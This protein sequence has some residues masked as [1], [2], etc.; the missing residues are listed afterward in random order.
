MEDFLILQRDPHGF[1]EIAFQESL[2]E[3]QIEVLQ[4]LRDNKYTTVRSCHDVGKTFL[5][6][7]AV[8]WFLCS[9]FNSKIITSAPTFRQVKDILWRE[10]HVAYEKSQIQLPG[11]VLD[12]EWSIAPDWFALGLSTNEPTRLQGFHADY[13][14][15]L[16]D[17]AAGI[18]QDIFDASE[19]IVTSEHAKILYL[20]NP[21]GL[22]GMFYKSF[23]LANFSKIHISAFDSPNFTTFG[24]TLDDIRNGKWQEKI[25]GPLPRPYLITP[26]WVADKLTRWG[27]QSPMW[28]ARVL[29]EF[30]D[31]GED[32]LIPLIRIEQSVEKPLSPLPDDPEQIGIDVARFGED[33]S[34]FI[35]RKGP[36][37]LE[38]KEFTEM[39][40]NALADLAKDFMG[41]HPYARVMIDEIGVGAGVVD[42]LRAK[43]ADTGNTR[44]I[45][46]INVATASSKP[47]LFANKRA[48]IFWNLR[49]RF[50]E[51]NISIPRD[52]DLMS[53][54]S[55]LKFEYT[56]KG[57]IRIESK[58]DMKKR[59]LPSPDKAD[60]LAL[61]FGFFDEKP[62]VT[63]FL[64][65]ITSLMQK[66]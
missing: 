12:T 55:N 45:E 51:G 64:K 42:A 32:T 52:E 48:E 15:F 17:E 36:V 20:G 18:P 13:L 34:V 60:A 2:W 24:I 8:I 14:L 53:Q 47:E 63:Q 61:A 58:E 9:F 7:R 39:D 43:L 37:L 23:K 56:I 11:Q 25:T 66:K 38:T 49:T 10:M 33:K 54:L 50:M 5:A 16:A 65:E 29:G 6:A 46:G 3:K 22:E 30:P 28:Q 26:E 21:T 59:G 62:A 19:G 41:F 35:H 1:I 4:S 31:Q 27:E 40:T 44:D 57:Q